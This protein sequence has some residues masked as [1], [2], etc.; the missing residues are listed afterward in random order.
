MNSDVQ[1]DDVHGEPSLTIS[2]DIVT[3][4]MTLRGNHIAPVNFLVH[5]KSVNPYSLAPWLPGA[6]QGIDPLLDVL[7]GDFWCLPFGEQP[8]GPAHGE[9][10]RGDW[11]VV[12]VNEFSATLVIQA[13]DIHAQV[14]KK[15]SVRDG[16]N[17]LFQEI[18]ISGLE[19]A[20]SYGTH[21]ILDLSHLAPGTARI[22]TG[23][24][25]WSS[26]FTG[27]F[28][29]PQAGE[30]QV[31][32]AGA[33]FTDLE[34]IPMAEGGVLDLSRY[35]T[36]MAH[37]DLVMVV[38]EGDKQHLGWSAVS[39]PGHTWLALKDVR[40]FP[41]TVFWVSNGG[42][43]QIPWEGLHRGRLGVEDVCSYFHEGLV[44]SR[45]NRLADKGIPTTRHFTAGQD[46]TLR[47]LQAVVPTPE[48]FGKVHELSTPAPGII[49]ITDEQ[50]VSVEADLDWGF[51]I[52]DE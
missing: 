48:N 28:S 39:I 42:R 2:S 51:V 40:D 23:A 10:A 36:P 9:V 12:D 31:L 50:G 20:Y 18:T 29:D 21:P 1:L 34:R 19:G 33:E 45:E 46:T 30:T 6:H 32:E 15:V 43:T 47:T 8:D 49:H 11:K 37:E 44:A 27:M 7:R 17:G 4:A 41:A 52:R 16:Q 24:A 38:Q 5:G 3:A 13:Q 25:R 35:P 14:T 22:S 26:V